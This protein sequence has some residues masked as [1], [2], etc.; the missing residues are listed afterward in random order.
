[1][2]IRQ[3]WSIKDYS[4]MEI[5]KGK[6]VNKEC[7][8]LWSKEKIPKGYVCKPKNLDFI[9]SIA[10]EKHHGNSFENKLHLG[11][12]QVKQEGTIQ[13]RTKVINNKHID[14][15][16]QNHIFPDSQIKDKTN[17]YHPENTRE[18][19]A[20]FNKYINNKIDPIFSDNCKSLSNSTVEMIKKYNMAPLKTLKDFNGDKSLFEK[21]LKDA[22]KCHISFKYNEDDRIVTSNMIVQFTKSHRGFYEAPEQG[23]M[24]GQKTISVNAYSVPLYKI[25]TSAGIIDISTRNSKLMN[26]FHNKAKDIK[27]AD[28]TYI[29]PQITQILEGDTDSI[30]SLDDA[31]IIGNLVLVE[32]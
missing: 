11:I 8:E 12:Y 20:T 18:G 14:L 4:E 13:V 15:T 27:E 1:V 32:A 28:S 23:I 7:R 5:K 6:Q 26:I 9:E 10:R 16:S 22:L 24:D 19:N 31:P 30:I 29:L 21:H 3:I 2:P 17:S 25:D